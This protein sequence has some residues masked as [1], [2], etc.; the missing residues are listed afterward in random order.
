MAAATFSVEAM[1]RGYHVYQGIWIPTAGEQLPC[2]KENGNI[3]DP[4]SV[5]VIDGT[6]VVGHVPKKISSICSMFLQRGGT[7]LCEITSPNRRY[8]VDLPLYSQI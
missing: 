3:Q 1:V 5:A 4:F 2:R 6:D 8:S 7:I